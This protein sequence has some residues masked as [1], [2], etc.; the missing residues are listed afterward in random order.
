MERHL[1]RGLFSSGNFLLIWILFFSLPDS[2]FCQELEPGKFPSPDGENSTVATNNLLSSKENEIASL[3]TRK[4]AL[5]K[6]LAKC[7]SREE[8][9][10]PKLDSISHLITDTKCSSSECEKCL[11]E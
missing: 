9:L 1:P 8:S 7:F 3:Y 5:A 2:F 11:N 6:K 4:L 10:L